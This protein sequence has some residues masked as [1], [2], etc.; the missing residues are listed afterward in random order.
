MSATALSCPKVA[1]KRF[2]GGVGWWYSANAIGALLA[3]LS[4]GWIGGIRRQGVAL[5]VAIV[6]WGI[7]VHAAGLRG[8]PAGA[9]EPMSCPADAFNS[10]R[11]RIV[12]EPGS[13]WTGVW[14][15]EP[16]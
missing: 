7:A 12:L 9:V 15:I 5:T 14:G 1:A 3:S 8:R 10:G 4:S 16:L 6:G 2:H 11:G 13:S